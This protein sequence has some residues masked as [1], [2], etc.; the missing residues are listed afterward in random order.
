MMLIFFL[1]SLYMLTGS[2]ILLFNKHRAFLSFI[3]D[4]RFSILNYR[5][6][7]TVVVLLGVILALLNIFYPLSPG[8]SILGD[9]VPAIIS[10]VLAIYYYIL[11]KDNADI[12]QIYKTGEKLGYIILFFSIIHIIYPS[13]ILL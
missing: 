13:C 12:E 4:L 3:M 9:L 5:A 11:S 2:A 8:P 6:V 1:T 7:N 10:L